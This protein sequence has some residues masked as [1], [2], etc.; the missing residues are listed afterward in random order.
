MMENNDVQECDELTPLLSQY[1]DDE[2]E[3]LTDISE[4]EESD[5]VINLDGPDNISKLSPDE[6]ESNNNAYDVELPPLESGNADVLVDPFE[7]NDIEETNIRIFHVPPPQVHHYTIKKMGGKRLK[8]VALPEMTEEDLSEYLNN[9]HDEDD[10]TDLLKNNNPISEL[11]E[12][13]NDLK[14]TPLVPPP[15]LP[16]LPPLPP[17]RPMNNL[18]ELINIRNK[19]KNRIIPSNTGYDCQICGITLGTYKILREHQ[20]YAHNRYEAYESDDE[21]VLEPPDPISNLC[22]CL[23]CN[24]IFNNDSDYHRHICLQSSQLPQQDVMPVDPNG[25]YECPIC[26][27]KYA[28]S[29]IL[30]EHFITTHNDYSQLGSL[31]ENVQS[32]GFPGFDILEE[33]YMIRSIGDDDIDSIINQNENCSICC[34]NFRRPTKCYTPPVDG[35]NDSYNSDSELLENTEINPTEHQVLKRS[36]SYPMLKSK[37]I[38]QRRITDMQLIEKINKIRQRS[39]IPVM[40]LCCDFYICIDCLRST[41]ETANNLIC[42]FC[43]HDHCK[44]GM[45]AFTIIEFEFCNP[46]FWIP[47]WERHMAIFD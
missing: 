39:I 12:I 29:N 3:S 36:K 45:N 26:K 4:E 1:S 22:R 15:S 13:I 34:Y 18:K 42:P 23:R 17:I 25:Q 16:S 37:S 8:Q 6:Y 32:V 40:M 33:L 7:L 10:G 2:T 31:D 21:I 19:Q 41:L 43:R 44:V 14:Q 11:D 28:S 5:I 35:G 27:N 30:G 47:W 24:R 38:P 46:K 20:T 9:L